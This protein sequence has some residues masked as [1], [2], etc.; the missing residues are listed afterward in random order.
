[1]GISDFIRFQL[2]KYLPLPATL[3]PIKTN[4]TKDPADR[5][6]Q[7]ANRPRNQSISMNPEQS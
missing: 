5:G 7:S 2:N 6:K 1:M 4:R 3:E